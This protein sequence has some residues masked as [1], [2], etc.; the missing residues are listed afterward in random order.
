MILSLQVLTWIVAALLI[1]INAY[2]L[3]NFFSSEVNGLLFGS[4]V[5]VVLAIY[6]AFVSYLILRGFDLLDQF[7]SLL[8]KGFSWEWL[9]KLEVKSLFHSEAG[10]KLLLSALIF[11]TAFYLQYKS[12]HC[13]SLSALLL[14]LHLNFKKNLHT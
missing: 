7:V 4:I 14:V 12:A 8:R 10:F 3:L 11:L 2:L 9:I 1:I 5:C 6:I 13:C